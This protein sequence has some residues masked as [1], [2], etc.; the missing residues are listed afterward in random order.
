MLTGH[1]PD[2][3]KWGGQEADGD[4]ARASPL[5]PDGMRLGAAFPEGGHNPEPL[6]LAHPDSAV[7]CLGMYLRKLVGGAHRHIL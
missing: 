6:M 1:T 7:S 5:L 3:G 4:P 2:Q